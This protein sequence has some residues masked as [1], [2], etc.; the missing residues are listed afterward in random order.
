M[1]G[2][3]AADRLVTKISGKEHANKD[4]TVVV[5]D[6]GQRR[7]GGHLPGIRSSMAMMD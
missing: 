6:A 1:V 7:I 3:S 4:G 2:V 5:A